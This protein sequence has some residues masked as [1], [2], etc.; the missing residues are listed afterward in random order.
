MKQLRALVLDTALALPGAGVSAAFGEGYDVFKVAGK[1][2]AIYT[3]VPGVPMVVVKCEPEHSA[4]LRA[5]HRTITQGYHMNKRHWISIAA[6]PGSTDTL[7]TELLTNSYLLVVDAL[8]APRRE[9][10][11]AAASPEG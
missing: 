4:A 1:V 7:V 5:A 8:P 2:F 11:R 10:L 6:G 3:E 9:M